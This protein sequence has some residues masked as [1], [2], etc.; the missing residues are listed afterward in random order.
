MKKEKEEG[1]K[2]KTGIMTS[3]NM[4]C[5]AVVMLPPSSSCK[6]TRDS[7]TT[8]LILKNSQKNYL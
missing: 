4:V 2:E 6:D 7:T 8:N 5:P 3:I 1:M